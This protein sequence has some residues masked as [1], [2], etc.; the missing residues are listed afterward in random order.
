MWWWLVERTHPKDFQIPFGSQDDEVDEL[1]LEFLERT[2]VRVW[3][4][5][6]LR[7]VSDHEWDGSE[8]IATFTTR[9]EGLHD[10]FYPSCKVFTTV[11]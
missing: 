7:V 8:S 9:K 5:M 3:M 10:G 11:P 4:Q 1:E 6:W 2:C